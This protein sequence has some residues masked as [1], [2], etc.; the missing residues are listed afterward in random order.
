MW[1]CIISRRKRYKRKSEWLC[2]TKSG[3][4]VWCNWR[5]LDKIQAINW[6]SEEEAKAKLATLKKHGNKEYRYEYERGRYVIRG[7]KD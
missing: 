3:R 4:V 5:N 2:L 6:L 1:Q 7:I